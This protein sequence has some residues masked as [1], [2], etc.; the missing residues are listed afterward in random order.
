[1]HMDVLLFTDGSALNN[2]GPTGAGAVAYID[3]YSNVPVLMKKG[4]NLLVTI[5]LRTGWDTERMG[6]FSRP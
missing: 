2:L 6:V 3:G 4:V 5:T 1:M